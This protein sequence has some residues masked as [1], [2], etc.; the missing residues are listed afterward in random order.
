MCRVSENP[1]SA[2][3]GQFRA[4]LSHKQALPFPVRATVALLLSLSPPLIAEGK[5]DTG[6]SPRAD[7][8]WSFLP[9]LLHQ[10][11]L[12]RINKQW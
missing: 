8:G 9:L 1:P 3:L 4:A 6:D 12:S 11:E 2:G 7:P 5:G 10:V